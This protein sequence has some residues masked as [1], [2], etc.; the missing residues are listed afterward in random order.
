M[1][2]LANYYRPSSLS[3]PRYL[4]EKV[5]DKARSALGSY[6]K[7]KISQVWN[8]GYGRKKFRGSNVARPSGR[9]SIRFYPKRR[10][11]YRRRYRRRF[12]RRRPL[13]TTV[14]RRRRPMRKYNQGALSLRGLASGDRLP[15]LAFG[16]CRYVGA[17]TPMDFDGGTIYVNKTI[18]IN[19]IVRPFVYSVST[20]TDHSVR[21]YGLYNLLYGRYAVLGA[22]IKIR[23]V[24][25][26]FTVAPIGETSLY[27]VDA[28]RSSSTTQATANYNPTGYWYVRLCLIN[29]SGQVVEGHPVNLADDVIQPWSHA[30][31]LMGDRSVAWSRDGRVWNTGIKERMG[32]NN[33]LLVRERYLSTATG[34]SKGVTLTY[35]YSAKKQWKDKDILVESTS[36]HW[37]NIKYDGSNTWQPRDMAFLRIGYVSFNGNSVHYRYPMHMPF[38]ATTEIDYYCAFRDPVDPHSLE[39]ALTGN[40]ATRNAT[41]DNAEQE[42]ME[43]KV[44]EEDEMFSDEEEEEE[45]E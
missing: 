28:I 19:N 2:V 18:M 16:R 44:R 6:M 10:S 9:N 13:K 21:Y 4:A 23:I 29:A 30:A 37:A 38:Y 36:G 12:N 32:A 7:R 5:V 15:E 1:P 27:G 34:F 35:K 26:L 17:P 14:F 41:S 22:R 33:E 24:P 20:D 8:S 40:L 39:T 42:Y 31:D 3:I 11:T 25:S 45:V 43:V